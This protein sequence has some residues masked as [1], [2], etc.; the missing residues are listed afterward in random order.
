[1]QI[2]L[3]IFGLA[4][5]SF[6]NVIAVRYNPAKF[7][8]NREVLGGRS[9]CPKCGKKLNWVELFPLF[10]FIFLRGRCR[11]CRANISWQYPIVELISGLIFVLVP[12]YLKI[13]SISLFESATQNSIFFILVFETLLIVSLID[14]RLRLIPDETNIFLILL[15]V[16]II[17]FQKTQFGLVSG[18]FLGSYAALFGF[19]ENIWVN[20]LFAFFFGAAFFG[21][22]ILITRGRGMGFGDL[23]MAAALGAV[24]GWADILLVVA[25]SFIIGSLFSLPSLIFKKK[26]LK[27]LLPFGPFLAM[28]SIVVFFFGHEIINFYFQLFPL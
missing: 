2:W 3:F 28:A 4:I 5:G 16:P 26:G 9:A 18:S 12:A 14:I 20:H 15:S 22:L 19:R 21:L 23:K 1:M 25:L 11:S 6:V 8:L 27:S 13:S 10:S 7:I 24:F 17:I